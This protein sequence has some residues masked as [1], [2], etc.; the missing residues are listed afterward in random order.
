M[1]KIKE[2]E[3]LKTTTTTQLKKLYIEILK[4]KNIKPKDKEKLTTRYIEQ[5][6]KLKE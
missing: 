3:L 2:I 5:L 6:Y 1:Y 4:A